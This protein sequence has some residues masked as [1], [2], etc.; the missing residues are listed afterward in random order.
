MPTPIS[1]TAR[2]RAELDALR[3]EVASVRFE[4]DVAGRPT[5]IGVR[6]RAIASVET[7]LDTRLGDL[8]AP[9]LVVVFGPTGSGKSTLTNTLAGRQI[10][11]SGVLR[12][13]TTEAVVWCHRRD[14]DRLRRSA[15][16]ATGPIEIVDDDHQL[17]Q[18]IVVIDTP[19]I[20]SIA[21][22]HR[23]QTE[24]I[25]L[26]ADAAIAVTTPQRYAD[27]VPWELLA[28]LT[29]RGMPLRVVM[30]R[31][32]RRSSGAVTDLAALLRER[33]VGGV[34][35][36]DDILAIQE[37]RVRGDGRLSNAS[38]RRILAG[39]EDLAARHEE[40][41]GA[42]VTGAVE[43]V[44]ADA[45]LLANAIDQLQSEADRRLAAVDQAYRSQVEEI[46]HQL[47]S[48]DLVRAEVVER[49]RRLVGVGDLARIVSRGAS[50]VR[51]IVV[52][53]EVEQRAEAVGSEVRSE[54]FGMT[55]HRMGRA[56]SLAAAAWEIDPA[57]VQLLAATEKIDRGDVEADVGMEI[58]AWLASVVAL[59][60]SQGKSRF[61]LAR[62]LTIGVNAAATLILLAVFASTGGLTGGEVGVVAG[63]A[64]AQQTILE[65][66]FGSAA[67][68][69]L[70]SQSRRDL[71]RR[72]SDL[73]EADADRFRQAVRL[74]LD[75]PGTARRL[76]E[77]AHRVE[78]ALVGVA[79]G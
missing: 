23:I 63:T 19:D 9:L 60:A 48:G 41:V 68:S 3:D 17:L 4:L 40:V 13:T 21:T 36:T 29:A 51:D 74:V 49:W 10:S 65:H 34:R 39:L 14:S 50:R 52:P 47:A 53:R 62:A 75:D 46:E 58:D 32:D 67:A 26:M 2:L 69:R 16:A 27:A 64:A 45:L 7:H 54:L 18:S 6:N 42:G 5:W 71:V 73:L 55:L 33:G 43:R 8:D 31:T 56:S 77:A 24:R 79:D 12:P 61:R 44:A 22:E 78:Q 59:V 70:A 25:L 20:D 11:R 38:V 28:D 66:V 15:L 1:R 30:N 37:Q 76:R 57:G 35:S 72:L